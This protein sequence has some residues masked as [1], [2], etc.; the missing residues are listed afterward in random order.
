MMPMPLAQSIGLPPHGDYHVAALAA[1]E[2]RP[3]PHL[4]HARVG[5]DLGEQAVVDALGLQAGLHIGDPAG[6]EHT[7]SDTTSTLRAPKVLA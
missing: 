4:L 3:Q 6:G 2:V 7:G 5:R 1:V